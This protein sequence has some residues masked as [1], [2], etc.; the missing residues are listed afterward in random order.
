MIFHQSGLRGFQNRLKKN[1]I[2][3]QSKLGLEAGFRKKPC[4]EV[5][6]VEMKC[7]YCSEVKTCSCPEHDSTKYADAKFTCD[8]CL[9]LLEIGAKEN[10]LKNHPKR[11]DVKKAMEIEEISETLADVFFEESFNDLW[12]HE[13]ENLKELSKQELAKELFYAGLRQGNATVLKLIKD[14]S[15]DNVIEEIKKMDK[16]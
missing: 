9:S 8:I 4:M 15:L 1:S 14:G 6:V 5:D 13:K 7:V 10:E 11:E 12:S 16:H 3:K 2:T